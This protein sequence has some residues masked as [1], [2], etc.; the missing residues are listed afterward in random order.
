MEGLYHKMESIDK[1]ILQTQSTITGDFRTLQLVLTYTLSLI[2]AL[3]FG[4]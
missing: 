1:D 4:F 3:I 2:L